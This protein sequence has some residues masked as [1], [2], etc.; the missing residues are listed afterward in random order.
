MENVV[1]SVSNAGAT[2]CREVESFFLNRLVEYIRML[3]NFCSKPVV[4]EITHLA[5]FHCQVMVS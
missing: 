1:T 3:L 2:V 4:K 5:K